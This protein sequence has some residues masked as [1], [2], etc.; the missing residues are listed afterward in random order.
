MFTLVPRSFEEA[1]RF[2]NFIAESNV[3]P[4][5]FQKS[6]ANVMVVV[7]LG[8]ELGVSPM[9]SIQSM[10]V[11]NGRPS[12]FGDLPLA[13]VYRSGL[14]EQIEEQGDEK[15]SSCTVKRKGYPPITRTFSMAE[16]VRAGLPKR[17]PTYETYPKRMLQFRSRALALRDAF[18]DVLKGVWI[19]E[20]HEEDEATD[21]TPHPTLQR[22]QPIAREEE[23]QGPEPSL[24][25]VALPLIA[26]F[27]KETFPDPSWLNPYMKALSKDDQLAVTVAFNAKRKELD[28]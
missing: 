14:L 27:T 15:S 8:M 22:P 10:Y 4:K 28:L 7:Q 13:I 17:N 19:R 1:Y 6:P 20:E 18:P 21:V 9:Q 5:E 12:I 25:D 26:G 3:I 11:V 24:R 23:K 16:A 2:A